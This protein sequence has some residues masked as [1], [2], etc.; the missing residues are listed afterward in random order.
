[1]AAPGCS[2]GAD[3]EDVCL[4]ARSGARGG[5][6]RL[7]F[8]SADSALCSVRRLCAQDERRCERAGAEG[9]VLSG[10]GRGKRWCK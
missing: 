6:L 5:G 2:D 4:C 3:G 1:V 10:R 8:D 9:E 7:D